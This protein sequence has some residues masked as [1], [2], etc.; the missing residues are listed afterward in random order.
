[1]SHQT[2]QLYKEV[3]NCVCVRPATWTTVGYLQHGKLTCFVWRETLRTLSPPPSRPFNTPSLSCPR[4]RVGTL[5]AA[6]RWSPTTRAVKNAEGRVYD[7]TT[8]FIGVWPAFCKPMQI[9]SP[10]QG[11]MRFIS[12][13]E[14]LP[15]LP[16]ALLD[17]SLGHLGVLGHS[18]PFGLLTGLSSVQSRPLPHFYFLSCLWIPHRLGLFVSLDDGSLACSLK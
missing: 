10:G 15:P 4:P 18:R 17:V 7:C 3:D 11:L 6:D 16:A 2:A 8:C 12:L 1:M 14:G 5:L 13:G 9:R